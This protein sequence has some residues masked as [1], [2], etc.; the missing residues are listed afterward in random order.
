MEEKTKRFIFEISLS[1]Y[2]ENPEEAWED[3]CSDL[4]GCLDYQKEDLVQIRNG[5]TDEIEWEKKINDLSDKLDNLVM[6]HKELI[7]WLEA[8]LESENKI[9]AED[10]K[11][12]LERIGL[13]K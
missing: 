11:L 12:L 8:N 5:Q 9:L 13:K 3:I 10:A 4:S 2:G 7:Q 6:Q 1:G